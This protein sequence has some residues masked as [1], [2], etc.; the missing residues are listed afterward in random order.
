MKTTPSPKDLLDKEWIDLIFT[1][2]KM[3]LSIEEI[4]FFLVNS[5]L[6]FDEEKS[7][8]FEA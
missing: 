1:A 4:R 3:G 8:S 7:D 2:R 6:S 5:S